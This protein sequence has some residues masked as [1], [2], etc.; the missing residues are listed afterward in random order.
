MNTLVRSLRGCR[1]RFR[2]GSQPSRRPGGKLRSATGCP[3][4]CSPSSCT[5][6]TPAP[7]ICL[8]Q[9]L[10]IL[11]ESL[12]LGRTGALS[13]H[14]RCFHPRR[15]KPFRFQSARISIFS[16]SKGLSATEHCA[17]ATCSLQISVARVEHVGSSYCLC[18]GRGRCLRGN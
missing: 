4:S 1:R 5:A 18:Q 3:L 10:S 17:D 16:L 11:E 15:G 14:R 9:N 8:T 12:V 7:S 2:S 6:V 13:L